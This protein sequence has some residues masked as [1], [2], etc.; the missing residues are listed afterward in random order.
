MLTMKNPYDETEVLDVFPRL[1]EYEF[2]GRLAIDLL[3]VNRDDPEHPYIEPW[4]DVT[5][6]LPF[7]PVDK[8]CGYLDTN[9]SPYILDWLTENELGEL[10][11]RTAGS[12]FCV[13][14]EF[15]F[16]IKRIIE[17]SEEAVKSW[18]S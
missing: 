11:G 3:Y 2:N 5:V 6:N 7:S 12:G 4:C 10:T 14:P 8:N 17:L 9:N 18:R 13:Y 1:E 15:R 16:D